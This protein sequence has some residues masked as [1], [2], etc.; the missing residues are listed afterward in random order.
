MRRFISIFISILILFFMTFNLNATWMNKNIS[1]NDELFKLYGIDDFDG[2][3]KV[4]NDLKTNYVFEPNINESYF[5][6][7]PNASDEFSK[8][9]K[10]IQFVFSKEKNNPTIILVGT[11]FKTTVYVVNGDS[12]KKHEFHNTGNNINWYNTFAKGAYIDGKFYFKQ[13]NCNGY[14]ATDD[15]PLST[16]ENFIY[17]LKGDR[18]ELV[19]RLSFDKISENENKIREEYK[20]DLSEK[21]D[22][23][24]EE[25]SEY[26]YLEESSTN[27]NI[28]GFFSNESLKFFS[29]HGYFSKDKDFYLKLKDKSAKSSDF[30]KG[31]DKTEL[32]KL[33]HLAATTGDV[34][35]KGRDDIIKT[36]AI[37]TYVSKDSP[38]LTSDIK[39]LA[40]NLFND[41]SNGK[42]NKKD[43]DDYTNY[44]YDLEIE[45]GIYEYQSEY[46][47]VTYLDIRNDIGEIK[48][49]PADVSLFSLDGLIFT[50][51]KTYRNYAILEGYEASENRF[52]KNYYAI[53]KV[54]ENSKPRLFLLFKSEKPI[55]QEMIESIIGTNIPD[56]YLEDLNFSDND[57][58]K[59]GSEIVETIK[60]ALKNSGYNKDDSLTDSD[61]YKLTEFY[62]LYAQKRGF[63]YS[64]ET[65][66]FNDDF[67][68][69]I[70]KESEDLKSLNLFFEEI[71]L[72]EQFDFNKEVYFKINNND[73]KYAFIFEN[74]NDKKDLNFRFYLESIGVNFLLSS[75]DIKKLS[76]ENTAFRFEKIEDKIFLIPLS[77]KRDKLPVYIKIFLDDKYKDLYINNIPTVYF[78]D[79]KTGDTTI[80][81]NHYGPL[82]FEEY[83]PKNLWDLDLTMDVNIALKNVLSTKLLSDTPEELYLLDPLKKSEL[84]RAISILKN[85]NS[86]IDDNSSITFREFYEKFKELLDENSSSL[87]EFIE[88]NNLNLSP[89]DDINLENP[90]NRKDASII[91]YRILKSLQN[92]FYGNEV[93]CKFNEIKINNNSSIKLKEPS[94]GEIRRLADFVYKNGSSFIEIITQ[95]KTLSYLSVGVL[96][97]LILIIILLSIKIKRKEP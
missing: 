64:G 60:L 1:N 16:T 22:K 40:S 74:A 8:I 63:S 33:K 54:Y 19:D 89:E 94:N 70:N 87:N 75:E 82:K 66:V 81:L 41:I 10:Y 71:G 21:I 69:E 59:N 14:P 97:I 44:L 79:N 47:I 78:R 45:P 72:N 51:E 53:K 34:Y 38:F 55:E 11:Y 17:E 57:L 43:L 39:N 15:L 20:T 30:F 31:V 85:E 95:N 76:D 52:K 50:N 88:L 36:L 42:I 80:F 93:D 91:I 56:N 29:E 12:F 26:G 49:N 24:I 65:I 32:D 6:Q 83:N 27:L 25:M 7:F 37:D 84:N 67:Y 46:G 5:T 35:Y 9:I 96:S 61:K 58:N 18:F 68:N 28:P 90:I 48:Y 77:L 4:Y 86:P 73:N 2:I 3:N 23:K 62:K 92:R 13:V